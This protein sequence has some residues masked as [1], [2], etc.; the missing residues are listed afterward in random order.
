MARF[1]TIRSDSE[2]SGRMAI[3]QKYGGR[4]KIVYTKAIKP[5]GLKGFFNPE[6]RETELGFWIHDN[7]PAPPV[8]P[9]VQ[10][11]RDKEEKKKILSLS[12]KTE[13]QEKLLGEITQIKEK[14]EQLHDTAVNR[15][16]PSLEMIGDLLSENDF[17][18]R[19]V[20]KI[21]EGLRKGLTLDQLDDPAAVKTRTRDLIR[22]SVPPYAPKRRPGPRIFV[23][24]G[25]T[26]VGKT[27]TIAK[28]AAY[29]GAAADPKE[30]LDVKIITIDCYR[31]GAKD[32]IVTYGE[33]MNIPVFVA[34][35][36]DELRKHVDLNRDA[37]MIFVDTIG[38]SPKDFMKLAE[39]RKLLEGCGDDA[40]I[41]LAVSATTKGSDLKEIFTQFEPFRY[42]SVVITKL[43]ETTGVGNL[44]SLLD[45]AGKPVSYL[46]T[47]QTVPTDIQAANPDKL[48][49]YVKGL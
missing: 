39:I 11:E 19:Y 16:H 26:G 18:P 8:P 7:E 1:E 2:H 10:V 27:T 12:G 22:E 48:V 9:R 14:L 35:N 45:E 23:L 5:T 34:D 36:T 40:E 31:I 41:H 20:R 25:P 37:D 46:T 24:V 47:G 32:Q 29:Y 43:D 13:E 4:A 15:E 21:K 17:T 6:K 42:Q 33:I 49:E 3:Y 38:K 44:L 28:L 30:S